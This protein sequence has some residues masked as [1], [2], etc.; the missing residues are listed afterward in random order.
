MTGILEGVLYGDVFVGEL[1]DEVWATLGDI[2]RRWRR[3]RGN[4]LLLRW[5]AVERVLENTCFL[6]VRAEG[7]VVGSYL[8]FRSLRR[9]RGRAMELGRNFDGSHVAA[10]P[11]WIA[12]KW[13]FGKLW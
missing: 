7:G 12:G 10:H 9:W 8:T 6:L 5:R 4:R 3:R 13:L 11:N 2:Y 1:A